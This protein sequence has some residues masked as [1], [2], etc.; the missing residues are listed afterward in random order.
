MRGITLPIAML[1][2]GAVAQD[3][4]CAKGLYMI[5]ARGTGEEQGTGVTGI[6]AK[7][8][9]DKIDD[10]KIEALDYPATFTDPDYPVSEKDGVKAMSGLITDYQKDCPEGKIAVLGYSQGGQVA[11]DVFCGGSGD[12][13]SEAAALPT[14]LVDD[15]GESPIIYHLICKSLIEAVVAIVLF[16]DP[17]HVANTSYDL[18]TSIKDG[19]FNRDNITLCED[20]SDILRSYCDTG[21]VYCDTG[22]NRTVHA[23]YVQKY[24]DEVVDFV[25]KQFSSSASATATTTA[26]TATATESAS[27]TGAA[28]SA[29]GTGTSTAPSGTASASASSVPD[30]AASGLAPGA[31]LAMGLTLL[32]A[33]Y[34]LL[35]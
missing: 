3:S 19:I 27:G 2:V 7:E 18:G 25:V 17:S 14:E 24:G 9:A 22:N 32:M 20:Y 5:V 12:G 35:V 21:D 33:A 16:G 28:A 30:N 11:S 1:A 23:G 4:T 29:T 6:L 34:E 10:S 13:F 15:S 31:A 26:S 8:I